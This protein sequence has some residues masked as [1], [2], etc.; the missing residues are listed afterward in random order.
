M[1]W[2][3]FDHGEVI[4]EP[5]RDLPALAAL[6][7]V[8]VE[9]FTTGYW[10]S[11]PAYD[12]GRPDLEYWRA[13][14]DAVGVPVDE[15]L[16]RRLTEADVRGWLRPAPAAVE[17]VREPASAGVPPAL[18]SNAPV[19]LARTA[20]EQPWTR[21]FR[22]LMFSGD[23]GVAK[24]DPRIFAALASRIGAEPGDCVF[25]DDRPENVDGANAAGLVGVLWQGPAHARQVLRSWPTSRRAAPRA[26][27]PA[28]PGPGGA[29]PRWPARPRTPTPRPR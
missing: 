29:R 1:R 20:E 3:V 11:R 21:H 26:A 2:V 15:A 13:V 25:F 17:L 16:S 22:H 23:V 24:P 14:G 8:P 28:P 7:G 6:L 12:A 10:A 9:D 5:N 27:R 4:S 18:L 19:S